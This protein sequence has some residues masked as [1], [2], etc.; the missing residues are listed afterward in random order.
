MKRKQAVRL[1]MKKLPRRSRK[2]EQIEHQLTLLM[3][4]LQHNIDK[5][6][7]HKRAR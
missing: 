5:V 6:L 7:K 1:S 3:V 4:L 2:L